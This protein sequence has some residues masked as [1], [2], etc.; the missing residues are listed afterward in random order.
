MFQVTPM[1][2]LIILLLGLIIIFSTA[3]YLLNIFLPTKIKSTVEQFVHDNLR[4]KIEI[5]QV[6]VNIIQGIILKDV[7]LYEKGAKIPYIK[8]KTLR[9]LPFLPS[10]LTQQK[11][12]SA[13]ELDGVY[14]AL[15][16]NEDGT[17]A[18]SLAQL[19]SAKP[20]LFIST[21]SVKKL[22]LDFE[23]KTVNFKKKILN[24]S[25]K[26]NFGMLSAWVNFEVAWDNKILA[27][28]KYNRK[29]NAL[30]AH[31]SIKNINLAEYAA[32]LSGF[33]LKNGYI[34]R[35]EFQLEG[36]DSYL[37]KGSAAISDILLNYPVSSSVD[38]HATQIVECKGNLVLN[39]LELRFV[40]KSFSYTLGG[41]I[42]K[43]EFNNAPLIGELKETWAAFSLDKEK[44]TVAAL[45]TNFKGNYILAKGEIR[46]FTEPK[47][48][49][50]GTCTSELPNVMRAVQII[51]DFWFPWEAK[52][53]TGLKFIVRG[54]LKEKAFDYMID[55]RIR[56]GQIKDL[57]N[58]EADGHIQN[59]AIVLD[60]A[61][62]EYKKIPLKVKGTLENFVAIPA[63]GAEAP[64]NEPRLHL[65][66][67][68]SSP[69]TQAIDAA[70]SLKDFPFTYEGQGSVD[71]TF[72]IEG[73]PKK[74]NLNYSIDYR[75]RDAQIKDFKNIKASGS[76]KNDKL[77]LK[78]ATTSYR[79][80]PLK[81]KGTMENFSS[82]EIAIT[83]KGDIFTIDMQ[84]KYTQETLAI[85]A[86]TMQTKGS[87]IACRANV[88]FKKPAVKIEGLGA[89]AFDDVSDV[90]KTFDIKF[91]PLNTLN[92][93]GAINVKFI[94]TGGFK[95]DEWQVKLAGYS[96]K[97]KVGKL[98]G[99]AVKIELYKDKDKL[100]ISPLTAIIAQGAVDIRTKFDF[101]NKKAVANIIANDID[102]SELNKQ[103]KWKEKKLAGKVSLEAYLENNG[104]KRWEKLS[105][106]GK[107][108]LKEGNIWE[109][110][111]LTGFGEY[112]FIPDFEE[113]PFK[114]GYSDLIFK[115]EKI[116]F[117]NVR[118]HSFQMD[119]QGGGMLTVGGNI[120]FMLLPQFNPDLIAASEGL[121]KIT[122]QFLGKS[123]LLIEIQ[124]TIAKPTYTTKPLL[125]SPF[126]IEK[127][128]NFFRKLSQ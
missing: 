125:F 67:N 97:L 104:L 96:E 56:D 66:G 45:K 68:C 21:I 44:L 32:Y 8:I 85:K 47:V 14:Y 94:I 109:L 53:K 95:I 113:I 105:G 33:D 69:L 114:E 92:P 98:G 70:K 79:N 78:D 65:E 124:G 112:L 10:L 88:T 58:I 91:S 74:N 76:I 83:A 102:L 107:I 71:V 77:F 11:V 13:C 101:S 90:L 115:G 9:I 81:L 4:Q 122:T 1:K 84:A 59:A 6:S 27:K 42:E 15:K 121:R 52:G 99:E 28:G 12:I 61:T 43:G 37:L 128:K 116:I 57:K 35:G 30:K 100:I 24:A 80:I 34:K 60:A 110:N 123:G 3:T 103:L 72:T 7:A 38:A 127:I 23:D 119:L 82:P 31:A 106:E 41:Y 51:G 111:F 55:Y 48:Y 120:H 49:A 20:S 40:Q 25:F 19:Q 86:L 93:Q 87:K 64:A 17:L 75:I 62:F 118:L 26:V 50:Q 126:A 54:N 5:A 73:N 39:S 36:G 89:I 22:Y 108:E 117:E 2:K 63:Q 18:L 46:D 29:N 16:R